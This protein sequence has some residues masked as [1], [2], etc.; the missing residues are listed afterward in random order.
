[1]WLKSIKF[2]F[3][4]AFPQQPNYRT[5]DQNARPDP[6]LQTPESFLLVGPP[7]SP[8]YFAFGQF[9]PFFER[10]DSVRYLLRLRFKLIEE[11]EIFQRYPHST[12]VGVAEERTEKMTMYCSESLPTEAAPPLPPS[13][14]GFMFFVSVVLPCRKGGRR[15]APPPYFSPAWRHLFVR[16]L[17]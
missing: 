15:L 13:L 14:S 11:V 10:T 17:L 4:S 8:W 3:I 12:A 6:Y 1:M 2:L 7:K 9:K 5:V 16:L